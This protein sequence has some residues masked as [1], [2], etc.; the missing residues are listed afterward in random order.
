[1]LTA[2]QAIDDVTLII[3]GS[4]YYRPAHERIH[5]AIASLYARLE[6]V[7]VI[8]VADRL[9]KAGDLQ[10]IGGPVYLHQLVNDVVVATNAGYY[11]GIVR[12]HADR[13]RL[14]ALATQ[15]AATAHA[16]LDVPLQQ[17]LDDA[18]ARLDAV[19][20]GVPGVDH[21]D[22]APGLT[23]ADFLGTDEDDTYDW[24]VPEFLE[25]Q[26]RLI[27][28]AAEGVG[29]STLMRQW[30]VQIAA[31][32]HPVTGHP[33]QPQ[34]VL[35]LDLENSK[36][37]TRRKLRPLHAKVAARLEP[38]NLIVHCKTEGIDLTTSEDVRWLDALLAAHRPDVLITGPIYKMAGGNPNDEVDAKPAALNLDAMRARHDLAV[39]LEA[40]SRK[41]DGGKHRPREPYGWSG[42]MRW[43]E[44]GL[45]LDENGTVS[46]WRGMRDERLFPHQMNKGGEWPWTPA[47]SLSEQR[48]NDIRQAFI[49]AGKRLSVR[50]V[51]AATGIPRSSVQDILGRRGL[52]LDQALY[53]LSEGGSDGA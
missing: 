35:L 48:F 9:A 2:R 8:T 31:G 7:D 27:L 39:I 33:A 5:D 34:R 28:T 45:H 46:H 29:K 51:E 42:W 38:G 6:P 13:R 49:K 15:L 14:A 50:E 32:I 22:S 36:R 3:S 30:A 47:V 52:E 26:D 10:R 11:A 20:T 24:L 37:Q 23:I 16:P 12:D 18:R 43:P 25:R 1:M 4:D 40:H 17:L 19:P 21:E 53:G 44:F 41:G